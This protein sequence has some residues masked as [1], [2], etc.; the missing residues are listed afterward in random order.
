MRHFQMLTK[1]K[2]PMYRS[3][4]SG[5]V[6]WKIYFYGAINKPNLTTN[7]V[8]E[9]RST[10]EKERFRRLSW[11]RSHI[12]PEAWHLCSWRTIEGRLRN[13][14]L[15]ELNFINF[16]S[17]DFM[18][19]HIKQTVILFCSEVNYSRVIEKLEHTS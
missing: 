4:C 14:D 5:M 11:C 6:V 1:W 18:I 2:T 17:Y 3:H 7:F 10:I 15:T 19:V 13:L 12:I 9:L 8:C 16:Y